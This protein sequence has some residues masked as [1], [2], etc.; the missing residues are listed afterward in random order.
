MPMTVEAAQAVM[1]NKAKTLGMDDGP[2]GS[3]LA[4]LL[5]AV[6]ELIT[7]IQT[8]AVITTTV[9]VT[10][11]SGVVTGPSVSG[12]GAGTGAGTIS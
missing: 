11:V 8:N 9:A 3:K 12:P 6:A 5:T 2:E 4:E 1:L 7:Y 10:N